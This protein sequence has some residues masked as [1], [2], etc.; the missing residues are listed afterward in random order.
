[1]IPYSISLFIIAIKHPGKTLFKPIEYI[2]DK[3]SLNIYIFHL[4]I[5]GSIGF[6]FKFILKINIEG[7]LFLWFKPII[8]LVSTIFFAFIIEKI[9]QIIKNKKIFKASNIVKTSC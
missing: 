1:M 2:G 7:I 9:N 4:L 8:T 6:A 3:L 5:A